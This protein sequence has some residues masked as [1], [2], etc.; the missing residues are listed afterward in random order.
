MGLGNPQGGYWNLGPSQPWL[1]LHPQMGKVGMAGVSQ[2][3]L[4]ADLWAGLWKG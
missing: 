1:R 4:L 3:G 2:A